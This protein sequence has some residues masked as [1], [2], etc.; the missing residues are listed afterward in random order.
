MESI[1]L[2]YRQG[3]SDKVYQAAIE[4]KDSGFIVT[5]AYGRRG[6][7]LQAGTKTSS[8]VNYETARTIYEK[9]IN[10]KKA[11]GYTE[12]EQGVPF[13]HTDAADAVSG[14]LPQLCNPIATAE[15]PALLKNSSFAM[16]EKFDGRRLLIRKTMAGTEGINRRGLVVSLPTTLVEDA[17]ALPGSFILDGE[18]LGNEFVVF[19]VLLVDGEDIRHY[20]FKD[21]M[22]ALEKLTN[23]VVLHHTRVATTAYDVASKA[24]LLQQVRQE[25]KEGVVF[26]NIHSPYVSGR[27]ASGGNHLKCKFTTTA[28]FIVSSWNRK[29][30]VELKLWRDKEY[31]VVG[32]VTIPPNHSIPP[33]GAVVEVQYLYAFTVSHNI[34]QPVYL[35]LRDDIEPEQCTVDQLKYKAELTPLMHSAA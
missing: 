12:G 17:E 6:S 20:P 8:P 13:Q 26:K 27:P 15:V 16:Q 35:G 7:S 34:F 21:R 32:N 10:E 31:L 29:R 14:V 19:D 18:Q 11:K 24:A 30:S 3:S 25:N 22:R 2:Y 4:P 9:L 5:F 28:S 1:T 33:M 23:G